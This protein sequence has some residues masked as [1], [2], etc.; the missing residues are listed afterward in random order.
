VTVAQDTSIAHSGTA[1]IRVSALTGA[2]NL[3]SGF[4]DNPR[5]VTNTVVGTTYTQSAWVEP[6]FPGQKITMH[7]REWK[8]TTLVTDKLVTL[9]AATTNW[10]QVARTLTAGGSGNQL[11]FAVY[12]TSFSAGQWFN[13]DDFS[14]TTPN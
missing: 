5:W 8:G 11:S 3:S 12:A 14:L 7:L 10:Q 1:S 6:G 4:N 9:T 2:S 13:A